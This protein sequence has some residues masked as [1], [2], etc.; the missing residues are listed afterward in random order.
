MRNILKVIGVLTLTAVW[1][2]QIAGPSFAA[3]EKILFDFEKNTER[4]EIPDWA[5]EK[6]DLVAQNI[7]ASDE[8]AS[9]GCSS[10]R[11]MAD[12]SGGRWTGTIIEIM[13]YFDWA[14]YGTILADVYLPKGTPFGLRGRIILTVGENWEWVEM[15]Q[16]IRLI[17]GEWTTIRADLM[18]G[19][20]DWKRARITDGFRADV[21]KMIIRVESNM[22]PTYKGPVYIDNIR[23]GKPGA[24][25]TEKVTQ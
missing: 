6:T 11:I 17:P 19:S 22:R 13:E 18:P 3:E 4:W 9:S 12:F 20:L 10:L 7:T 1:M 25:E 2:S 16:G 21:R 15:N 24:E 23:V 8:Y 5:L 14:R